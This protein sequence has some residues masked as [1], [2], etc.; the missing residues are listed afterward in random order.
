MKNDRLQVVSLSGGR[1]SAYM[2]HVLLTEEPDSDRIVLFYNT[3]KE[4]EE[5]LDFVHEIEER[6]HPVV[7]LEYD[8]D[9]NAAGTVNTPRHIHRAVDFQSAARNGEPFAKMIA[10]GNYLPNQ[11]QRRC[12]QELKVKTGERYLRRELGLQREGYVELLG[13]RY[14]EPRRWQKAM[15][16]D[17]CRISFPLVTRKITRRHVDLFW[18]TQSFDLAIPSR[19]SNCDLCFLKG[20]Q[21]LIETIRE[22]PA[23]ADWWIEQESSVGATFSSRWSYA[24]LKMQA[25]SQDYLIKFE[26]YT[27]C[28]CGE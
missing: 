11:N 4:R 26:P 25:L 13:I 12:T 9:G 23:R 1:S 6:W 7:W 10:V 3:G 27:S 18:Q 2:L 15:A 5:T 28:Y 20:S 14:D 22:E 21:S 19:L 17:E 8:Y 24:D 16:D